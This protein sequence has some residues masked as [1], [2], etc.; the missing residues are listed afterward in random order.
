MKRIFKTGSTLIQEDETLAALSVAEIQALLAHTYPELA[1]AT[2]RETVQD[3]GT[4]L[5]EFLPQAGRKG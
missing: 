1:H 4:R 5:I 2:T 3:D